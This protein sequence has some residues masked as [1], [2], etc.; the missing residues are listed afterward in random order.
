MK[1][2][3]SFFERLT[4]SV[5]AEEEKRLPVEAVGQPAEKEEW[6]DEEEEAQLTI[7]MYQT[8]E[9]II[10]QTIIAGIDPADLNVDITPEMIT[11]QGRREKSH[12]ASDEDYFYQELYWGA[13]SRSIILPQEID[14]EG[15]EAKMKNGLLTIRLPKLDKKRVHKLKVKNE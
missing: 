14:I 10:I 9:E 1:K 5:N 3:K 7:D 15:S 11:I 4:G 13:F 8:P 12:T 2:K 6:M